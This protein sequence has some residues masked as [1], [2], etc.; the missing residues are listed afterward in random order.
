MTDEEKGT[1]LIEIRD[2]IL[3]KFLVICE[4]QLEKQ[5][6]KQR[7]FLVGESITIADF[8]V[9]AMVNNIIKNENGPFQAVLSPILSTYP[10]FSEYEQRIREQNAAYFNSRPAMPF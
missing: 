9:S 8:C 7:E 6:E 5:S 10:K 4:K 2:G 1:K 3:T